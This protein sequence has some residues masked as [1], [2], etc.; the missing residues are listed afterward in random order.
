MNLGTLHDLGFTVRWVTVSPISPYVGLSRLVTIA[1]FSAAFQHLRMTTV[2]PFLTPAG[3]E[4]AAV[5]SDSLDISD[6]KLE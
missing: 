4:P 1:R 5:A 6:L 2:V 3:L